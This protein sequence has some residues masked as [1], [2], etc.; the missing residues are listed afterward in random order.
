MKI[1]LSLLLLITVAWTSRAE[2]IALTGGTVVNPA[3]Q[4]TIENAIVLVDGNTIQDITAGGSAPADARAIDCKG[5]FILP[6][7]I[8]THVHFFQSADLFTR[9]DGVD[10]Y[11]IR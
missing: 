11:K 10:L 4:R 6:G 9:P 7:Y 2:T 3:D 5:K 1:R 8:D